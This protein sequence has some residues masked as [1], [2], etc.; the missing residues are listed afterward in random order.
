MRVA[1]AAGRLQKDC[2]AWLSE[3]GWQL[4]A[5]EERALRLRDRQDR[6]VVAVRP[7]DIPWFVAQG[8][9]DFGIV[10]EDVLGECG[11]EGLL[12]G[13]GLGFGRCRLVV[14]APAGVGWPP[15]EPVRLATKYPRQAEALLRRFGL[16]GT[17]IPLKG[18]V[19]VAP[20]LGVA[21]YVFDL[22]ETGRTLR[23]NGLFEVLTVRKV[24]AVLIAGP[25]ALQTPVG[26]AFW[27]AAGGDLEL[28]GVS[29]KAARA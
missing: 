25:T 4:D 2:L 29:V 24:E 7:A 1:I 12:I 13:P 23:E 18:A 22:V 26:R 15:K 17:V 9:V 21:D 14:A 5:A 27:Q 6:E 10:G 8:A 19:E 11:E 16:T 3:M 20:Y 28:D